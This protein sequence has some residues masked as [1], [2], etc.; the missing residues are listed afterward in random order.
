MVSFG[1]EAATFK[2]IALHEVLGAF[3]DPRGI[4]VRGLKI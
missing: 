3:G 4:P 2:I 1:T